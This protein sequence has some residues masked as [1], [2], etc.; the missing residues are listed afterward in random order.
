[1]RHALVVLAAAAVLAL[2]AFAGDDA[3]RP[4]AEEGFKAIQAAL[5]GKDA[6][7]ME[8]VLPAKLA[9]REE[10]KGDELK[11]WRAGMARRLAKGTFRHAREEGAEA[12]V[13]FSPGGEDEF[14]VLLRWADSRWVVASGDA[15]QVRGRLLD[16]ARGSSAAKV[17]LVARTEKDKDYAK[18]AF[19]FAC[20]TGD[21]EQCKNRMDVWFDG[22]CGQVHAGGDGKVAALAVD[23][24][25]K[26]D[27]LPLGVEWSEKVAPE[28]GRVLVVHCLR[29][30]RSDFY[31]A[32]RFTAAGE[33]RVELEWTLLATGPGS[34]GT[35]HRAQPDKSNDG[36]DGCD[37]FCGKA[38]HAG[39]SSG[40][41]GK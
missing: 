3:K 25:G 35:I 39:T 37:G 24:L 36:D 30:G 41:G 18:S 29:P 20:V 16:S 15:Y 34:P 13:R 1:M 38:G 19:S 17:T 6:A 28:K 26:V 27:G 2:P 12:A 31:V 32:C 4:T 22:N 5:D 33:S 9:D 10:M 14:E 21:P 7:A 11:A 40:G 23:S 8:A